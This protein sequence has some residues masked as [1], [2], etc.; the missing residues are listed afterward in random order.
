M[1]WITAALPV[2][3][4]LYM[5]PP[6]MAFYVS[7]GLLQKDLYLKTTYLMKLMHGWIFGATPYRWIRTMRFLFLLRFASTANTEFF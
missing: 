3:P 5:L 6:A 1:S 4:V 7:P 2:I